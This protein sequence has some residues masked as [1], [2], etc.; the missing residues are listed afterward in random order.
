MDY[1]FGNKRQWRRWLWNRVESHIPPAR[2]AKAV[3]LFLAGSNA[4]DI[5]YGERKGF[6]RQNFIAVERDRS[7][8]CLLRASGVLTVDGDFGDSLLCWPDERQISVVI[9]DFCC[10]LEQKLLQKIIAASTRPPARNAVMAFNFLRGRDPSSAAFRAQIP[11]KHRG[12]HMFMAFAHAISKT[13]GQRDKERALDLLYETAAIDLYEYKSTAGSQYFDSIVF[14]NPLAELGL[15][16][17]FEDS[18]RMV[19]S[20]VIQQRRKVSAVLAHHTRRTSGATA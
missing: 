8:L 15:G 9:G 5:E 18:R 1:D 11:F 2:R 17:G 20:V 4:L 6:R 7:A 12:A 10:G 3:V 13:A 16:C 19:E 14:K